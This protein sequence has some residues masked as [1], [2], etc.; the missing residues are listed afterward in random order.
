MDEFPKMLFKPGASYD[1]DGAGVDFLIVNDADEEASAIA[2]G[3]A[4]GR[5]DETVPRR[6]R[7]AQ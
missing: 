1:W 4:S 7:R 3:W 5:P 6:G 2:D